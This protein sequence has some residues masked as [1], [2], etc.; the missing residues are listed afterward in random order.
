MRQIEFLADEEGDWAFHC[1]KSHHA[2]N[3]MGHNVPTMIG[4]DHT[5]VIE[6][7]KGLI[8]DYMAMSERGMADMAEMQMAIPDNTEQ[9]MTGT[10]PFGSVEMGG[11]FSMLKV[12]GNQKPGDYSDPGWFKH[13]PG[14]VA[15]EFAGELP[16]PK[17]KSTKGGSASRLPVSKRLASAP[18][19]QVRVRKPKHHNHR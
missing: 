1:H 14:T 5:D 3:A 15:Y 19:T 8:P 11:M 2:M 13:P 4:V 16:D 18:G 7:V 9:M 12:R 17:R 6:G 10:G